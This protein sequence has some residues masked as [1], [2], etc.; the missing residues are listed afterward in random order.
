LSCELELVGSPEA[1]HPPPLS[2]D[3]TKV[4]ARTLVNFDVRL[5]KEA[6]NDVQRFDEQKL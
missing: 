5:F 2:G 3:I 6:K 4:E 1:P